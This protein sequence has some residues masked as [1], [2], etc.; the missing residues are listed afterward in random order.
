[1]PRKKQN[2]GKAFSK[3][4]HNP[5][6]QFYYADPGTGLVITSENLALTPF[7]KKGS[8]FRTTE[9]WEL[10]TELINSR[11]A[12]WGLSE[13][14]GS[15]KNSK[16]LQDVIFPIIFLFRLSS[17]ERSKAYSLWRESQMA[18]L[19]AAIKGLD[20]A[21]EA[22]WNDDIRLPDPYYYLKSWHDTYTITYKYMKKERKGPNKLVYDLVLPLIGALRS[23]SLSW[24]KI[25]QALDDVFITVAPDES[26]DPKH[27]IDYY[28]KIYN[29]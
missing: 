17:E 27:Y 4:I 21:I 16:R 11:C 13:S 9:D 1:M 19:E 22:I 23:E 10:V 28:R 15:P 14:L 7:V 8:A 3:R 12:K 18:E 5:P 29:G 26:I 24:Y 25:G 2:R 6:E 20:A